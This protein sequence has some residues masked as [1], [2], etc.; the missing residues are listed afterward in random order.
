MRRDKLAN[1]KIVSSYNIAR[2]AIDNYEAII[3][4]VATTLDAID[5]QKL[6]D[7]SVSSLI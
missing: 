3:N 2:Q 6:K 4:S 5:L 7:K 1:L